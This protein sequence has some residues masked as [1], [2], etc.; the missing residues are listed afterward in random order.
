MSHP[1]RLLLAIVMATIAVAYPD[2]YAKPWAASSPCKDNTFDYVV[3]GA[4]TAGLTLAARLAE[5][6]S[7]SVAVIEAGGYY[8]QDNGNISVFPGYATQFSGTDPTNIQPLVDWGFVTVPQ[9]GVD[10]RR[11]HYTRGKTVGGTSARNWLYYQ[12]PNAGSLIKWADLAG[13]D[14]YKF[15]NLLPYF[16][17]IVQYTPPVIIASNSTNNQDPNAWSPTG[18]PLQISHGN[19]VDPFGTWVQPAAEKLGMTR[20]D[21]FQSGKLLGSA[22]VPFT[23]DPKNQQ[24]SSSE[25]SFLRSLPQKARLQVYDHTLAQKILFDRRN[26]ATGVVASSNNIVFTLK[27]RKEVILSAG[28]FQSPQ[29]LML[30][31]IGPAATLAKYNIPL[32]I[33]LPGVGSNLQDHPWFG[34]DFRINVPTASSLL[35]S[36]AV[37]SQVQEA[38]NKFATGPLTIPATGF[39]AWEKVPPTLRS[40]LSASAIHILDTSFPADWPELEHIPINAYIGY[41]R[42]YQKEDPT[43]GYNYGTVATLL[44]APLSRGT[45]SISSSNPAD[46]P[47]IDPNYLS[48]PVDAEIAVAAVRRQRDFWAQMKGVT[49]GDEALPGNNVT[50]DEDIL[51]FVKQSLGIAP[52]AGCTCAMGKKGVEGSVVDNKARVF[53][54]QGLR[55]VDSSIFPL[56]PPGHITATVYA[57]AEK[58]ADDILRGKGNGKGRRW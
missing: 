6:S 49:I 51:A 35:N 52:H 25:S 14:S 56:L 27:A 2:S 32:R 30:S 38:Y 39:L 15:R 34:T 53:G 31:G 43:D 37:F 55:V 54:T 26:T 47:L 18:G 45:V 29:I 33:D 24:R 40:N 5:G 11:L 28:V 22:Y 17:K 16:K 46:P 23:I 4:G 57:I 10:G 9:K 19:F 41:Q 12:R 48:H 8:E 50:S 7:Y 58:I 36:P 20:I 13:D 42:N 1:S 44:A 3:I 21:G